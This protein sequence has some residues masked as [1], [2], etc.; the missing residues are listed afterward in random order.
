MDLERLQSGPKDAFERD[1]EGFLGATYPSEDIH[2]LIRTLSQRFSKSGEGTGV[3]LAEAVKGFGK[4]HALATAFHLF[5]NPEPAKR[6]MRSAGYDWTPPA[7]CIIAVD[8]FTDRHFPSEALWLYVDEHLKAG[9]DAARHPSLKEFRQ[10]LKNRHLILILDELERGI[11]N[12]ASPARQSQ[13]LSFLQMVSEEANK[14]H[15]VTIVAAVYDGSKEPGATLRRVR[16]AE[17]RFRKIEDRSAVVR[18][19]LFEEGD[20]YDRKAAESV[21]QSYLNVWQKFGVQTGEEYVAK[22]RSSYPFLPDLIDLV[23]GRLTTADMFQ[24]TRGALGLLAS[25]LDCAEE[26]IGLLTAAQCRLTDSSCCNRLQDLDPAGGLIQSAIKNLEDLKRFEMAEAVASATLL[27]SLAPAARARGLSKEELIRHAA[28]PGMDPNRFHAALE[29][30]SRYGSHF[31]AAEGR[32]FFDIEEN[33]YAKVEMEALRQGSDEKARM[34]IERIWLQDV[35]GDSRLAVFCH[36]EEQ[37]KGDLESLP[38][39][40]PRFLLAPRRLSKKERH[41]LYFDARERNQIILLEPKESAADHFN[42]PDLLSLANRTLAAQALAEGTR[43]AERRGRYERIARESRSA[44]RNIIKGGGCIYVRVDRWSEKE[45]ETVFED[46]ALGQAASREEILS[47]L[48]T[49]IYPA[50]RVEEHLR[51]HIRQFVGQ[52]V[53]DVDR[54][55]RK[56][57]GYPVPLHETAVSEAIRRIVEGQDAPVGLQHTGGGF[58]GRTV[59][60]AEPQ[61]CKARLTE[62]WTQVTAETTPRPASQQQAVPAPLSEGEDEMLAA[63]PPVSFEERSTQ[64]CPTLGELR[65]EVA[66]KLDGIDGE[67][68]QIAFT[69]LAASKDAEL[70]SFPPAFRGGLRGKGDLDIQIQIGFSGPLAKAEVE[71]LCESLPA[72]PGCS[73]IA[74]MRVERKPTEARV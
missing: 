38:I 58:C 68:R 11:G 49:Q 25:M 8:K 20:R 31:H 21:I 30:F 1:P 5:A 43:N 13:N 65:Q 4:S 47:H 50:I 10:A 16:G 24:G 57:L 36:D 69:V 74:R 2:V 14:S 29:S 12:I 63:L 59:Q 15:A 3:I 37:A 61:L 40:K 23:F 56:T 22:L 51:E 9:W 44:V 17:L 70:S 32:F 60:L 71:A 19:R 66:A 54:L 64:Y 27:A 33:E 72:F 53:E 42:N 18:H 6:W 45:E 52:A 7:D 46:E 35:F 34:E 28:K 73:Y 39:G 67:V 55:Y 41:L 48:R 26:D 62:P